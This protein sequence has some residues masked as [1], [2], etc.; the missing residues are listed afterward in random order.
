MLLNGLRN[1]FLR[2]RKSPFCELRA[3]FLNII[4]KI[5]CFVKIRT[6][7]IRHGYNFT[8]TIRKANPISGV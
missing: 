2:E 6:F 7:K 8:T 3:G 1:C 4:W 5:S